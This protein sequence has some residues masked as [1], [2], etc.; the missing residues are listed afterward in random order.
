V[1][2]YAPRL[3]GHEL[4]ELLAALPAIALEGPKGVGKTATAEWRVRT[5]IRLDEPG[6]R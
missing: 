3:V 6:P 5:V 4:D 2:P 1:R